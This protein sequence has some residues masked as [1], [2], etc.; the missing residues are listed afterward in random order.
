MCF[1]EF[2]DR[3]KFWSTFNEPNI[4]TVGGYD[5]GLFPPARCSYPYGVNCTE[6]DSTTEPYIVAHNILLAHASA[7]SL[8]KDKFQVLKL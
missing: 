7:A 5:V 3:V 6:G 8:Y 1:K 2:G 4:E